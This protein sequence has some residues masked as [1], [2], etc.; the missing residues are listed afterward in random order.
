MTLLLLA[1]ACAPS[2]PDAAARAAAPLPPSPEVPAEVT[3][4]APAVEVT[5]VLPA[6][7]ALAAPAPEPVATATPAPAPTP[8]LTPAAPIAG[9][10]VAG[11]PI[12]SEPAAA[13]QAESEPP[14]P[15]LADA[16][17]D[18]P[19]VTPSADAL[20]EAAGSEAPAAAPTV[21]YRLDPTRSL[22]YVRVFKDP[23]AVAAG[24]SHD[25]IIAATGWSGDVT[26]NV[27]DPG[28][29]AVSIT[30]PVAGLDPDA[31][32]LREMVG[33]EGT[34]DS[35]TR[36]SVRKNMLSK[37]Q[38]DADQ[39]GEIRFTAASCSAAGGAVNVT[40]DLQIHG[41]SRTV[42]VAMSADAD[43][44]RF[45]AQGDLPIRATDYG[46]K[47]FTAMLGALKNLDRMT[48]GINVSGASID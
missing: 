31:D 7:A 21:T 27:D 47:P 25:H 35:N 41:V 48:L 45:S 19:E 4:A 26:W 42:T 46:F 30:V 40:G 38:L 13:D 33:L 32:Y 8:E 11:E 15:V 5:A 37:A 16:P 12:A 34:L 39:F 9:A 6:E 10:P 44:E 43:G 18:V 1:L 28:Q 24:L 3:P 20:A 2:T 17:D 14:A 23:D 36:A 29:C 22:L